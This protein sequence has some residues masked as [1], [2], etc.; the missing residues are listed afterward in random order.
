LQQ[1]L[2]DASV[3]VVEK[4]GSSVSSADVSAPDRY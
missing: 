2:Y 4:P 1:A 3:A